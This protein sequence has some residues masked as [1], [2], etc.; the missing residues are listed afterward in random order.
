MSLLHYSSSLLYPCW[1]L[2]DVPSRYFFLFIS[3]ILPGFSLELISGSC[4]LRRTEWAVLRRGCDALG[5]LRLSGPLAAAAADTV[6]RGIQHIPDGLPRG[7]AGAAQDLLDLTAHTVTA[8]LKELFVICTRLSMEIESID[9]NW[10]PRT[11]IKWKG[12]WLPCPPSIE[13]HSSS[14]LKLFS[15]T[16]VYHS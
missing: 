11:K 14:P 16:L 13:R 15:S 3:L 10:L 4:V 5:P 7:S 6:G 9:P 8:H 2:H 12:N 1:V